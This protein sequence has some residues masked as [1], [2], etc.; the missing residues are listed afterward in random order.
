[1]EAMPHIMTSGIHILTPWRVRI[2]F[3]ATFIVL[4]ITGCT[5]T[6]ELVVERKS[7]EVSSTKE[8]TPSDA[9]D[10][11]IAQELEEIHLK[12]DPIPG[13]AKN[14]ELPRSHA[15]YTLLDPDIP[16]GKEYTKGKVLH[17]EDKVNGLRLRLF[18][19]D[20]MIVRI[21]TFWPLISNDKQAIKDL[22][23][24]IETT[25]GDP[26][27]QLPGEWIYVS[28]RTVLQFSIGG[29]YLITDMAD[30]EE[31]EFPP[32]VARLIQKAS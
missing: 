2:V 27:H 13:K 11:K 15:G 20:G 10:N 23:D 7:P 24:E 30:A 31:V 17:M 16:G 21:V 14:G 3:A 5:D 9:D 28:S 25:F 26:D 18:F 22:F 8:T 1:M 29:S 4:Q 19:R 6:K 32:H 12:F